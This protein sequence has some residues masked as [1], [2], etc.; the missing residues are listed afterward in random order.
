MQ[1]FFKQKNILVAIFLI[2]I[3][4][5]FVYV[6]GRG[7]KAS[8][9]KTARYQDINVAEF[10]EALKNDPFVVDVHIPEQRHILGTDLFL[11]YREVESRLNEL[12]KDKN[13]E[14]LVYCRTGSMSTQAAQVLAAAGYTNVKNLTGGT[15]TYWEAH[16]GIEFLPSSR[17]LGT[18]IYGDVAK[19][20]FSLTN[21]TKNR[22][23][24]TRVSTSCSCTKAEV[25]K[26]MLEPQ[27]TSKVLVTFDPA[28]HKDDTDLG[29]VTR[30]IYIETDHINF[31]KLEAEITATVIRN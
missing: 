26:T 7:D 20:E 16:Q 4:G 5:A 29:E 23:E 9:A 22:V 8:V 1:N 21:N 18:V 10:D 6:W 15:Q 24:I 12:P 25:E 11:D 14:I 31:M 3:I 30:V 13:A 17:N 2:W 28:V 27:E 19:T